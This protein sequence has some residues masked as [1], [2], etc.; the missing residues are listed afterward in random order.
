MAACKIFRWEMGGIV[1]KVPVSKDV[2]SIP[3][4][5]IYKLHNVDASECLQIYL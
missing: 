3:G 2:G 1:E 4:P 5:A